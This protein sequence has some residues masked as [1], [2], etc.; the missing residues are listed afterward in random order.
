MNLLPPEYDFSGIGIHE[1]MIFQ[2]RIRMRV[3]TL[4]E[5][6][7]QTAATRAII[8]ELSGLDLALD[9]HISEEVRHAE[10]DKTRRALHD[11]T[12]K[13]LARTPVIDAEK[14]QEKGGI[15]QDSMR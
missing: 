3:K 1:A 11:A 13:T 6:E 10:N 4:E 5:E 2:A 8:E 9:K 15:Q 12:T 14:E 7:K